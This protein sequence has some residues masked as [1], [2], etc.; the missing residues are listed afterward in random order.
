MKT[1]ARRMRNKL[2]MKRE[3]WKKA[4]KEEKNEKRRR[5]MQRKIPVLGKRTQS[6][7]NFIVQKN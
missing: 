1:E 4:G 2:R 6:R 7:K 3:K 5:E